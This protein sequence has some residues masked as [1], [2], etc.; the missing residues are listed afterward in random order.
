MKSP[1]QILPST[2]CLLA[3]EASARLE[4]FT[5][6]AQ[7]LNTSQSSISRHIA[8]LEAILGVAVF[9]RRKQRVRLSEPG[10][11]LFSKLSNGLDSI[12]DGMEQVANWNTDVPVTIGCTHAISHLLIM[13]VF[14]ALQRNVSRFGK[15]RIMTTEYEVLDSQCDPQVDIVFAYDVGGVPSGEWV[16]LFSEAVKPVCSPEFRSEHA[17]ELSRPPSQWRSIPLLDVSLPNR[18]WASWDD[19]FEAY[20]AKTVLPIADRFDNYIYLLEA[21]ASGR[22]IALGARGMIETY[23]TSGRLVETHGDYVEFERGF[24][25]VLTARGREKT[26]SRRCLEVLSSILSDRDA[27]SSAGK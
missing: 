11:L 18:G 17:A 6:A 3:F 10:K 5:A 27:P 7:L 2:R 15:V 19:W 25:A 16:H 24:Y 26:A 9:E 13:P 22:G 23:L 4:S 8:D 20:G 14:D 21:S 12:R 1:K